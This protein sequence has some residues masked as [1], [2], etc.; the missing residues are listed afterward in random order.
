MVALPP[1]QDEP[2]ETRLR[3]EAVEA[4]CNEID[5]E[6]MARDPRGYVRYLAESPWF[7]KPWPDWFIAAMNCNDNNMILPV[8]IHTFLMDWMPT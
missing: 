7:K 4:M 6:E 8:A 5:L 1:S 2:F 3:L